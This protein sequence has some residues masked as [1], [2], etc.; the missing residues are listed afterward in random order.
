MKTSEVKIY[1]L[2]IIFGEVG[3]NYLLN[4]INFLTDFV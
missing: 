1:L 4:P 2:N 3:S